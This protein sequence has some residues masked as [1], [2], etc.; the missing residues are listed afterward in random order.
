MQEDNRAGGSPKGYA[1][2]KWKRQGSP[3]AESAKSALDATSV[4]IKDRAR[5]IAEQQKQA[6]ADHSSFQLW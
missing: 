1:G 4:T 2:R 3:T 5:K 6:G